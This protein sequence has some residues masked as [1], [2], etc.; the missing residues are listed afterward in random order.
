MP[1]EAH[2]IHAKIASSKDNR[3]MVQKPKAP[4][5]NGFRKGQKKPDGSGRRPG[6]G[7]V[8]STDLKDAPKIAERVMRN[9]NPIAA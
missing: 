4:P 1:T 3:W 9:K 7:N 6:Q 2:A 8:L 5:V